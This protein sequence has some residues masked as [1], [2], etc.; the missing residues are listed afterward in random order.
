MLA[1][2]EAL[3]NITYFGFVGLEAV[4]KSDELPS[5][6]RLRCSAA[7]AGLRPEP[8]GQRLRMLR[9]RVAES[10]PSDSLLATTNGLSF[11]PL[12]VGKVCVLR[13]SDCCRLLL[14]SFRIH[15]QEIIDAPGVTRSKGGH[16]MTSFIITSPSSDLTRT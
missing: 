10:C 15:G 2:I 11:A 13:A 3:Q 6:T 9:R 16:D 14:P 12:V 8:A 4:A 5:A 7:I 1:S